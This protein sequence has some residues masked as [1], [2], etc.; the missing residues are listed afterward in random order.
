MPLPPCT[1]RCGCVRHHAIYYQRP[2]LPPPKTQKP[3]NPITHVPRQLAACMQRQGRA[4]A[5]GHAAALVGSCPILFY[6]N[7][8]SWRSQA[9]ARRRRGR[10]RGWPGGCCICRPSP[11][12]WIVCTRERRAGRQAGGHTVSTAVGRAPAGHRQQPYALLFAAWHGLCPKKNKCGKA[13]HGDRRTQPIAGVGDH[14]C[15]LAC[16]HAFRMRGHTLPRPISSPKMPPAR[17]WCSS[18][19]HFTAVRW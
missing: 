4:R 17:C 13:S 15:L 2:L 5:C 11:R 1:S 19:S 18:H 6:P 9:A 7:L 12:T 8:S 16:M 14:A 10:G 3:N